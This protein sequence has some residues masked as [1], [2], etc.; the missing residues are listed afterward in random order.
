MLVEYSTFLLQIRL[1]VPTG[2]HLE[3]L[4]VL[5][6]LGLGGGFRW[7]HC[8]QVT[9]SFPRAVEVGPTPPLDQDHLF[10]LG[11]APAGDVFEG[12]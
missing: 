6:Y 1:P 5:P 12:R 3:A 11:L 2:G 7:V 9:D 10:S 4:H 8:L